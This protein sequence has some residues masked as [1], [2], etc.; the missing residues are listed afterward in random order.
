MINIK[1][2]EIIT[3]DGKLISST[4]YLNTNIDAKSIVIISGAIGILQRYYTDFSRYLAENNHIVITYDYRGMGT[5]LREPIKSCNSWLH[6]WGEKD[7]NAVILWARKKYPTLKL[8]AV[9]HSIGGALFGL[10]EN[11]NQITN[12]ILIASPKGYWKFWPIKQKPYMFFGMF[13]LLPIISRIVGYYPGKLLKSENLP[14]N[15]ACQWGRWGRSKDFILHQNGTNRHAEYRSY[16]GNIL[17]YSF[18]DDEGFAPKKAVDALLNLYVSAK[19]KKRV[20]V[21]S[22]DVNGMSIHHSGFFRAKFKK[23]LWA[24]I[25]GFFNS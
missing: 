24:D 16:K 3:A 22:A 4:I 14:R 23:Y 19:S 8:N 17:S 15:V 6:E 5:S 25:L 2:Q 12:M 11:K 18:Y 1:G 7:L 9:C 13:F 20:H 21:K 10:S